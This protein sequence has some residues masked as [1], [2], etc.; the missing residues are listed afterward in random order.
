MIKNI[1]AILLIS[2]GVFGNGIFDLLD[3][4]T[5]TPEPEVPSISITEP[6]EAIKVVV[7]PVSASVD[8]E[9]DQLE[10]A[11]YFL[12]LSSRIESYDTITLQQ[13]NDLIVHSATLVFKGRLEGKYEGF[14][15]G[16][17]SEIFNVTGNTEHMLS[18]KEKTEL[19]NLFSG[20]AWSLVN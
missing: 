13:V 17:T 19:S 1:I 4:P 16:L 14:D 12:E 11:L 20:L 10:I 3:S 5:P 9:E 15:E 2:Y 7:E 6:S 8:N 18:S